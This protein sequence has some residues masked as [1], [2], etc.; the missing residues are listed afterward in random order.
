LQSS[1]IDEMF[2]TVCKS[3][4]LTGEM[5]TVERVAAVVLVPASEAD[6]AITGS[7]VDIDPGQAPC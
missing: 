5:N 1:V 4:L 6:R 3:K 2:Q 7:C